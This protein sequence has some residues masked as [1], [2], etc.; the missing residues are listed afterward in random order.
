RLF[1]G[2]GIPASPK[3]LPASPPRGSAE[4]GRM[5]VAGKGLPDHPDWLAKTLDAATL[6]ALNGFGWLADLAAVGTPE[7]R[8]RA[9]GFVGDWLDQERWHPAAWAPEVIGRRIAIALETWSFVLDPEG[10]K[11]AKPWLASLSR[12]AKHL[13]RTV[14][15]GPDGFAR[16]EAVA[17]LV[18]ASLAGLGR[19]EPAIALERLQRELARQVLPDGG[20]VERSPTIHA[21]VFE[22]L[23]DLRETLTAAGVALPAKLEA[24]I[25]R[26][27]P[28]LRFFRHIDGRLALFNGT[29]EGDA[30][31]LDRLLQRSGIK[32]PAP[33]SATDSGFERLSAHRTLVVFNSGAPPPRGIDL[34]AHAGQLSFEMSVARER[35]VV[36]CGGAPSGDAA[37]AMAARA[38]AAHSTVTIDETN[39]AELRAEGGMVRRPR[40]LEASREDADGS[41]L[42]MASHDG[43]AP[44]FGL[45]HR[46]RLWLSGDGTDLRGEDVLVGTHKGL[47]AVR[48]HLHP[49]IQ[50]SLIQN[51]GAALLRA[52]SGTAWRFQIAGGRLEL[53]D[54][55]YFGQGVV[56]SNAVRRT[57][58]L[59]ISGPV[60]DGAPIKWAF[61]MLP[62]T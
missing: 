52:P 45:T 14:D 10:D 31:F 40:R 46:R 25:E 13:A 47:F 20:H 28:M 59:V 17:G 49:E 11:L 34:H 54:S 50:V 23:L 18:L 39:S 4:R 41:V 16:L 33:D 37:W 12:Q 57:E 22:L 7:A 35:V 51:G 43:Y 8:K 38:T 30:R 58:Q 6:A 36:N 44:N 1:L 5:I 21:R 61:R 62:R 15:Q 29:T 27:A 24:A 55:A 42:A 3:T 19:I 9:R 53:V 60:V 48:F 2:G 26:M 56:G 32:T